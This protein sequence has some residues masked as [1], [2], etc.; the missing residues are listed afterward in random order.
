MNILVLITD[1]FP[2]EQTLRSSLRVLDDQHV[3]HWCQLNELQN[4]EQR[5]D[6]VLEAILNADRVIS[7]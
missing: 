2:D 5:W 3:L 7:L 4:D 1:T 6:D